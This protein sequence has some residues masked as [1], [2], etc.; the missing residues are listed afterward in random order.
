MSDRAAFIRKITEEV[1]RNRVEKAPTNLFVAGMPRPIR[2][3]TH[4][5]LK[6][7]AVVVLTDDQ[8]IYYVDPEQVVGIAVFEGE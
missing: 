4:F 1:D 5:D 8:G 3:V 6:E 2:D 7:G